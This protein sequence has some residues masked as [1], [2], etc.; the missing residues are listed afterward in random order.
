M[1][2][3]KIYIASGLSVGVLALSVL[4]PAQAGR[5]ETIEDYIKGFPDAAPNLCRQMS[6]E[7]GASNLWVGRFAGRNGNRYESRKSANVTVCFTEHQTCKRW[8]NA[9]NY[10]FSNVT[11]ISE[12]RKGYTGRL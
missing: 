10:Q 12:C 5:S 11:Y 3:L 8:L 7:V 1:T 6:A 4:Q 9:L 2:K